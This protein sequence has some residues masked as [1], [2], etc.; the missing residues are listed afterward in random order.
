MKLN[1][2]SQQWVNLKYKLL[3]TPLPFLGMCM[4]VCVCVC[5]AT[6]LPLAEAA[7]SCHLIPCPGG[8]KQTKR[9]SWAWQTRDTEGIDYNW[10][11]HSKHAEKYDNV[12]EWTKYYSYPSNW[13]VQSDKSVMFSRY[14]YSGIT[15]CSKEG[16]GI[17]SLHR[18]TVSRAY[19]GLVISSCLVL[20]LCC[21]LWFC[22][23][24]CCFNSSLPPPPSLSHSLSPCLARLAAFAVLAPFLFSWE[25]ED[26]LI[27][28]LKLLKRLQR[29]NPWRCCCCTTFFSLYHPQTHTHTH[30]PRCSA[31]F[32]IMLARTHC[33]PFGF[34]FS[35]NL[36]RNWCARS[37]Q[38]KRNNSNNNNM[39]HTWSKATCCQKATA[40]PTETFL[41]PAPPPPLCAARRRMLLAHILQW[42]VLRL[43]LS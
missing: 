5:V 41:Y 35:L 20:F 33:E 27:S 13:T 4:A 38:Y 26:K 8:H 39:A 34:L 31:L 24:L 10:T 6:W 42:K 30:T 19:F 3:Q 15:R 11:Q 25:L 40:T 1:F 23:Y 12:A 16:W 36:A 28:C 29:G 37:K 17:E 2:E 7:A 32:D 21:V 43:R 18:A 14:V 22:F 9:S